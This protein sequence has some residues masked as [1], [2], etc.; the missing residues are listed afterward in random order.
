MIEA[1]GLSKY[2]GDFAAIR[3]R[4]LSGASGRGGGVSGP[5]GAGKSTTMKLLTGYLAPRPAWR[6]SPATTCRPTGWPGSAGWATCP[7]TAP[8]IPI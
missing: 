6:A 7:R 4:H 2:Y 8:S 5:N 3:E 1:E